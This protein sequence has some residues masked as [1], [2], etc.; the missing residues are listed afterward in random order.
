MG[1]SIV[2]MGMLVESFFQSVKIGRILLTSTCRPT[3]YIVQ[4]IMSC[5]IVCIVES[6]LIPSLILLA[7]DV[8][9]IILK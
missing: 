7:N 3:L 2:D 5:W 4:L 1:V 6:F 8:D 9:S